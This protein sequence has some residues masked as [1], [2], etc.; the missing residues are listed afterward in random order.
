M[1][2]LGVNAAGLRSKLTSFYKVVSDLKPSVFFIQETKFQDIGKLKL[3]NYII[4]EFVRQNRDGGGGLA[5]GCDKDLNPAWVREGDDQVEA[6]SVEICLKNLKI[7]CCNAY[8]CQENETVNKKDAFW[9]YLDNEVLEAERAGSGFLLHFDGNLWAGSE[10]IPGDVRPQNNNGKLFKQFLERHKNLTVVNYLP[11]CQGLITRSQ[12]IKSQKEESILDF[13]VVCDRVLPYVTKMVIDDKK[14]HILTNYQAVKA[15][16]K[17]INSDH[18]TQ[19]MDLQVEYKSEKPARLEIFDYKNKEDQSKFKILTTNTEEFTRCF[20]SGKPLEKQFDVW[21]H[22]LKQFCK[23]S[24]RKIRIKKEK[25]QLLNEV[26][27]KLLMKEILLV[28]N[29]EMKLQFIE[30]KKLLLKKKQKIIEIFWLKI[31]SICQITQKQS[32][33]KKCGN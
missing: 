3:Q 22:T 10:I 21:M 13:F 32:I 9:T 5:L 29:R 26:I 25:K 31:S 18:F 28:K 27:V 16:G 12:K 8:G 23:K 14:T 1:R 19:Y 11:L 33:C 6:I 4:Y 24:F 17:A 20:E 7:R 2:F 30:L 15:G